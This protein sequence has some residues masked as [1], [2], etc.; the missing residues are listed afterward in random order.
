MAENKMDKDTRLLATLC[1]VSVAAVFFLGPFTMAVPLLIWL[2]ERNKSKASDFILFQAKQAFFY[3]VAVYV[4]MTVFG[5]VVA[6]LTLI[7]IGSLM[8]PILV[9]AMIAA[10]GYGVYGGVQIWN[11]KPFDYIYVADFMR[12]GES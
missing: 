8:V 5:L 10:V 6:L 1:H 9:L 7:I 12:A 4:L 3:Q 11:G 2:L